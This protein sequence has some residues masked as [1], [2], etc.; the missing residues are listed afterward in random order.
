VSF[1]ALF[2][3]TSNGGAPNR[4]PCLGQGGREERGARETDAHEGK[5][6]ACPPGAEPKA[7]QVVA[8]EQALRGHGLRFGLIYNSEAGGTAG[9]EPFHDQTLAALLSYQAAGG[10]P[11]DVI[12]QS[13]Y[14]YPSAMVPED[15][16]NRF[17]NTAKDLIAEYDV[18]YP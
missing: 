17:T 9:D 7:T 12:V 14:P 15:Q 6:E 13:W 5:A 18:A 8:L 4:H 11:D 16:A 1:A 3:K 2:T 10:N